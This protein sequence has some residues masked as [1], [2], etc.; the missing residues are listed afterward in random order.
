VS[1]DTETAHDA[2]DGSPDPTS[3]D[4][5]EVRF[6]VAASFS[7]AAAET[8]VP[9]STA[10]ATRRSERRRARSDE[11][12][13][14]TERLPY[15]PGLD[16]LRAV[17]VLGVLLY[18][19][20]TT[21]LPGGLLGVDVFFVLSGFLITSL[22]L[23]ERLRTGSIDLRAF[24]A[25]RVRRLLPA[26]LLLLLAVAGASTV[27]AAGGDLRSLR[28]DA[29]AAL[30][31][32]ANWRFALSGQD[33][34]E[35]FGDP[36]PLLHLWSLGVEEQFYLLWPLL[37][38]VVAGL[39]RRPSRGIAVVAVVGAIAS[40]AL[41]VRLDASD[42]DRSRLYYGTDTRALTL[43]VGAALAC[44]LFAPRGRHR[45]R[46][47]ERPAGRVLLL[48][49]GV[50]GAGAL[51]YVFATVDGQDPRL[52]SGGFLVVAVATAAVLA[53][54]VLRPRAW[55]TRL[56]AL[57][58]L[59]GL[60]RISYGLYLWHWPVF[61]VLDNERLGLT[62]PALLAVRLGA[63][64]AISLASYLLVEKPIRSGRWSRRG[65]A[66]EGP[67][68]PR[69]RRPPM[70][71][72]A[73]VATALTAGAVILATL[74]GVLP[75]SS[76][77][78]GNTLDRV[79]DTE[80]TERQRLLA[81]PQPSGPPLNRTL[82]ILVVG[83]SVGLTAGAALRR[84]QSDWDVSILNGGLAGCGIAP[85]TREA[86][87]TDKS[88][89]DLVPCADWP[90][91]WQ[92][93]VDNFRPD[94]VLLLSGRWET[95]DR[96]EG[97]KTITIDT[98]A[99]DGALSDAFDTGIRILSSRGAK[100][101]MVTTPCTKVEKSVGDATETSNEERIDRY[102][103]LLTEV[104]A[105]HPN[106]ASTIDLHARLCPGGRYASK[107]DGVQ[108]RDEDGIHISPGAGSVIA[109]LTLGT[110]RSLVGLSERPPDSVQARPGVD[111]G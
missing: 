77:P 81:Q 105:R 20:G 101:G 79:A 19:A 41:L 12:G 24:W 80:Y 22:L 39:V 98:P 58:P 62:D 96:Y 31:Y 34:F 47:S 93:V 110:A 67:D 85:G 95:I 111:G 15:W 64:L 4:P 18:H 11:G 68:R 35:R 70:L 75:G 14:S 94:V 42:V 97:R 89:P 43:L 29:L 16:G 102:N 37:V 10:R 48:L 72:V 86:G 69:R 49:L 40:T 9:R 88:L 2:R 56:L 44:M 38:L 107:L 36:S 74:P 25:R 84:V 103:Q 27:L 52:Y 92:R 66:T 46:F 57:P 3:P 106:V 82:R 78:R 1:L 7:E 73:P 32:V 90:Q 50:A 5:A 60:G 6:G 59:V 99:F 71:V 108:V 33:Y 61:L 104:T 28:T 65:R 91:R 13:T 17:A 21:W 53:S 100:V 51:G 23:E 8:P 87:R 63:T 45:R 55:L 76:G 83:D 30:L 109:P 54:V 26:L